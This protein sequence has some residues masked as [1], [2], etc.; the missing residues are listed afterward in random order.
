MK[1]KYAKGNMIIKYFNK[2]STDVKCQLFKSYCTNSYSCSLWTRY[3]KRDIECIEVAYKKV[4]RA[5][6]HVKRGLTST[7]MENNNIWCSDK[8]S[9]Q[10]L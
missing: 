10:E 1:S 8:K 5:L 3:R 7:F 4:I 6:F 9:D 2:C